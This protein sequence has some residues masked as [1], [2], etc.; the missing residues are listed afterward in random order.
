MTAL[1]PCVT[2][3]SV[4]ERIYDAVQKIFHDRSAMTKPDCNNGHQGFAHVVWNMLMM[5][6]VPIGIEQ[7]CGSLLHYHIQVWQRKR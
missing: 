1:A 7:T 6:L 3:A 4:T 2:W 5:Y